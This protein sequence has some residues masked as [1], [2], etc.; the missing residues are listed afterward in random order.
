MVN[1][2]EIGRGQI[3]ALTHFVRI[4]GR[5]KSILK[6]KKTENNC[7]STI[8]STFQLTPSLATIDGK[9]LFF[10]ICFDE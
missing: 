10:D 9:F 7:S 4:A 6:I 8:L 2:G 5:I 1:F 3:F